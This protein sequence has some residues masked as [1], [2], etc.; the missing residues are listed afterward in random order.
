MWAVRKRRRGAGREGREE[1]NGLYTRKE[2]E[3]E[4]EGGKKLG[5]NIKV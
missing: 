2:E 4:R 5:K 1:M 3:E